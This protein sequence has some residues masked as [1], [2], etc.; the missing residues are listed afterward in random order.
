VG[1]IP[2]VAAT[3]DKALAVARDLLQ[4]RLDRSAPLAAAG[5]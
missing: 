5:H 2:D 1:V 4:R 3:P